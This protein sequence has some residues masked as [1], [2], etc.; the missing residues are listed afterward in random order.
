MRI[1]ETLHKSVEEVMQFSVLEIRL[2]Y[3]WFKLQQDKQKESMSRGNANS[4][5]PRRR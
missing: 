1:A 5:N 2:W 4:R 3:E